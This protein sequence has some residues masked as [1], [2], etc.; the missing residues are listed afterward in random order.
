MNLQPN[1]KFVI[2]FLALTFLMHEAHELA[3]TTLGRI[4]CGAWGVRDFNVWRLAEGCS[5]GNLF[6]MLPT[7][8]G[9]IFT[10]TMIWIGAFLLA[11]K[12]DIQKKSLG[13]AFIF[14]NLPFARIL[15]AALGGGDEVYATSILLNDHSLAWGLGPSGILLIFAYPL[16]KGFITI[17]KH[18]IAWFSL[19]FFVPVII[20]MVVVLG[21]MNTLLERGFLSD[22]WILGSPILV[23]LWTILALLGFIVMQK[24]IYTLGSGRPR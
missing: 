8:V 1:S 18:R 21:L 10:F 22:Y 13:F 15:T 24:H 9:P 5:K 19:F 17:E 12:N 3:H 4:I 23:T 14:A 7:Y 2:S 20:D 6:T 16:Y 11:P